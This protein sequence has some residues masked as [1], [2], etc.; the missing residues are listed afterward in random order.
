MTATPITTARLDSSAIGDRNIQ[1]RSLE[2]REAISQLFEH[3]IDIVC[4]DPAGLV[5][6]DLVASEATLVFEQG[7]EAQR[8]VTGVIAECRD[9]LLS[10]AKH[11]QYRIRLVAGVWLF[12]VVET[13]EIYMDMTV[14]EIL[15]AKLKLLDLV[16]NE[17]YELRLGDYSKREFVVQY[18]ETDLD[19]IGRL[20][21]HEGI[22]FSFEQVGKRNVLVFSDKNASFPK[23]GGAGVK[24]AP[25]GEHAGVH[26]LEATTRMVPATYVQRDYNYRNPGRDLT[27][28]T[29]LNEGAGGGV[30]EYGGHF[31]TEDEGKRLARIRSQERRATRYVFDGD[32]TAPQLSA[33]ATFTLEGH[34]FGDVEL[35]LTEVEHELVQATQ[36][37]DEGEMAHRCHFKAITTKAPYRPPRRTPKPRIHGMLTGIVDAQS[38]GKYAEL[39]DQGRYRVKFMFDTAAADEGRASR[40]CRMMQPHSGAGYGMHFPLR[41]GIEVLITFLDGDPDRPI[42]AGTV[43]NPQ[44]ASPV[45]ASNQARNVIRTG[46][47]NEINIDDSEGGERIKLSTPHSNTVF[48]LGSPNAPE[49]G[50]VLSTVGGGDQHCRGWAHRCLELRLDVLGCKRVRHWTRNHQRG[51]STQCRHR[52]HGRHRRR[53]GRRRSNRLH[54]GFCQ[55][56]HGD[57]Q[58]WVRHATERSQGGGRRSG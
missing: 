30:I 48:Q 4:S 14:P 5:V 55:Q 54:G 19:F 36:M 16:K 6:D 26:R 9:L 53:R 12:I 2:S 33:G 32:S 18:K 52:H 25:R 31:K 22:S 21:E 28:S 56:R 51:G 37:H 35:L 34:P 38:K 42:I 41:P 57:G 3:E 8:R 39:D 13:L 20:T 29:T 46:G 45:A 50:A 49:A 10:E 27:A 24:F 44:T 43:P 23:L 40:A 11:A 7:G 47:N 17:D 15:E 1:L 58:R